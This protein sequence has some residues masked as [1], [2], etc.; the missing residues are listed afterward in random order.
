MSTYDFATWL[1]VFGLG[2]LNFLLWLHITGK[3]KAAIVI[4]AIVTGADVLRH[5]LFP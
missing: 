4:V 1:F 2:I 5:L 3:V